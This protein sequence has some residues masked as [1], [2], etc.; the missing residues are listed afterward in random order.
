MTDK[1]VFDLDDLT[2]GEMELIEDKCGKTV[3]EVFSGSL[4]A[5]AMRA[6]AWV[7]MRRADP[8][9]TW[10]STADLSVGQFDLAGGDD[11]PP[12]DASG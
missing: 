11:V 1:L 8:D 7:A 3:A 10:E 12:T 6:C 4:S 5:T 2:F 9:A